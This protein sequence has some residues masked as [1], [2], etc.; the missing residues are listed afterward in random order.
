[1]A[2]KIK[3][4]L[5]EGPL[6]LLLNLIESRKLDINQISISSVTNEYLTIIAEMKKSSEEIADF[7]VLASRLLYIKSK[8]LLPV[9]TSEEQEETDDLEEQLKEYKKFK[10]VS[11]EL[12]KI[13]SQEQIIYPV[14]GP[15]SSNEVF[16]PPKNIT[17]ENLIN[18]LMEVLKKIPEEKEIEK[19][20]EPKISLQ[21]KLI[22]L[23]EA[24]A[25]NKKISF[26]E[27]LKK[28]KSKIEIIVT[29]LA[30]L[31]M[32]RTR[33]ILLIQKTNFSDLILKKI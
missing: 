33:E 5:F 28:T 21:E 4:K 25:K 31:E 23:R 19:K 24:V 16:L 2:Y 29:F 8:A 11:L 9:I 32:S 7:L 18:I 15:E 13:L 30:V 10:E 3:T 14:K 26:S 1:M 6:D 20:L 22:F 27:L 17:L 12:E